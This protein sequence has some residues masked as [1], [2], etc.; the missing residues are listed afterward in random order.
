LP[1]FIIKI[2][3]DFFS[4]YLSKIIN[5]SFITGVFPQLCKTAKVIPIFK[6][7]DPLNVKNYRPISLLPIFSKIF[8]KAIYSRMYHY[9]ELNDLI[10]KRQFG[11]RANHSTNHALISMTEDIKYHLDSNKFVSGIFIDLEKA[12]D[13]VNHEI[14]CNKLSYYGFRGKVNDLIKSFLMNRT[15]FVSV[16]GVDSHLLN[17]NCGIPQGSTLGPLLFLLYINDLRFSLTYSIASHFADDACITY[18]NINLKN[19]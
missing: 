16:N 5:I 1:I 7:D 19:F 2:C 3:N 18:A 17:I 10:F 12:F 6:K 8:E 11:F 4:Y 15:Q 13:T 9:L 14:L